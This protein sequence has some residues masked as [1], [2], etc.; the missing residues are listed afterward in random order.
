MARHSLE[1]SGWNDFPTYL[2]MVLDATELSSLTVTKS[3]DPFD[4]QRNGVVTGI[5]WYGVVDIEQLIRH[6]QH[7]L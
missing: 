7:C 1:Q 5:L 2:S 6:H 3:D 4:E